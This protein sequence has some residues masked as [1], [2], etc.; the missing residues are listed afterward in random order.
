MRRFLVAIVSVGGLALCQGEHPSDVKRFYRP[1]YGGSSGQAFISYK[2]KA[3]ETLFDI[4]GRLMGDPYRAEV[5]AK[6]NGIKDPLRLEAGSVIKVP[7]PRLAIRYSIQRLAKSGDIAVTTPATRF[8][9]GD[10]F[11]IWLASNC[12]G[13]LYIFSR[14]PDGG[15]TR[16][17]PDGNRKTSHV[18]RF[19]E[20]LVPREGWLRLDDKRGDEELWVLVSIDKLTDLDAELATMGVK[21]VSAAKQKSIGAYFEGQKASN[22]KGIVLSEDEQGQ[23]SVVV[24]G[25]SEGSMVLAHK[26]VVRRG[27]E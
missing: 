3:G 9:E 24:D 18:R 10:R 25:P 14:D 21:P 26:I 19:S 16:I 20:Y 2:V 22:G 5:L 23:S 12:D 11:Q 13:Y 1:S 15:L 8:H 7:T 4:A 27:S 17:F 6:K